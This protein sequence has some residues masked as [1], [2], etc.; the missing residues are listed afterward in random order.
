MSVLDDFEPYDGPY[1]FDDEFEDDFEDDYSD[2]T[3]DDMDEEDPSVTETRQR[4]LRIKTKNNMMQK[5][6]LYDSYWGKHNK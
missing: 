6:N 1:S 5:D 2:E 4:A 3:L